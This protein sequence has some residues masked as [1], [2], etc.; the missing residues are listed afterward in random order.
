MPEV[1]RAED[2]QDETEGGCALHSEGFR[3]SFSIH[4]G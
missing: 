3:L 2:K 1:R 4:V